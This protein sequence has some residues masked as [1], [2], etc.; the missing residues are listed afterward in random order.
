MYIRSFLLIHLLILIGGAAHAGLIVRSSMDGEVIERELS[1]E[2][3][4]EVVKMRDQTDHVQRH[5]D[6][7]SASDSA[8]PFSNSSRSPSIASFQIHIAVLVAPH[9]VDCFRLINQT[10]PRKPDLDGLLKPPR[11]SCPTVI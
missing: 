9:Q 2:V 6:H 10:L 1:S 7:G 8:V 4:E 3:M 5:F 11:R